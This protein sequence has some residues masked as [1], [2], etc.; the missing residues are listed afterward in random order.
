MS[1]CDFDLASNSTS[2]LV[3]TLKGS[4]VAR[5]ITVGVTPTACDA[6]A[7]TAQR[8]TRTSVHSAVIICFIDLLLSKVACERRYRRPKARATSNEE[9]RR[10]SLLTGRKSSFLGRWTVA[11][12]LGRECRWRF[13]ACTTQ[14]R[15]GSGTGFAR[16][17]S[18]ILE[19]DRW[20]PQSSRHDDSA[21][22]KARGAARPSASAFQARLDLRLHQRTGS[23][24]R[25][26]AARERR[27]GGSDDR[28]VGIIRTLAASCVISWRCPRSGPSHRA[29]GGDQSSSLELGAHRSRTAADR[30]RHRRA[31]SRK[32]ATRCGICAI[33]C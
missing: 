18:R 11:E 27:S 8:V 31:W 2:E 9:Q 10:S 30:R 17:T 28:R 19:R 20:L 25:E 7:R 15:K 12:W 32:N 24:V 6:H 5:P 16:E 4:Y 1:T 23:M 22:G 26:P 33:H 3:F 21:M 14:G 29:R 13:H